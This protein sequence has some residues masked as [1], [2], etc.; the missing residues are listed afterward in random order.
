MGFPT[1]CTLD[2]T[3]NSSHLLVALLYG[4]AWWVVVLHLFPCGLQPV[5]HGMAPA[6]LIHS[7]ALSGWVYNYEPGLL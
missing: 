6:V 5:L 2:C 7:A 1:L 3:L 4:T